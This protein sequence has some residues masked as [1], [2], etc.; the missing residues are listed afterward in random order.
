MSL[1]EEL[2]EPVEDYGLFVTKEE[3]DEFKDVSKQLVRGVG[4][5]IHRDL[6]IDFTVDGGTYT[7]NGK[8][9]TLNTNFPICEDESDLFACLH[10][11]LAHIVFKSDMRY[12]KKLF[13]EFPNVNRDVIA[14]ILNIIEDIRIEHAWGKL[15]PGHYKA[16]LSLRRNMQGDDVADNPLWVLLQIRAGNK[17]IDN[18]VE[19]KLLPFVKS[20][21]SKLGDVRNS[22]CMASVIVTKEIIELITDYYGDST[23]CCTKCGKD[24][25]QK[26][27]DLTKTHY[28]A[29]VCTDCA[30]DGGCGGEGGKVEPS[31]D[32][33][34]SSGGESSNDG[35]GTDQEKE[36]TPKDLENMNDELEKAID[37]LKDK[38]WTLGCNNDEKTRSSE[39]TLAGCSLPFGRSRAGGTDKQ[40]HDNTKPLTRKYLTEEM[41][42]SQRRNRNLMQKAI[43]HI[44]SLMSQQKNL[45]HKLKEN[46]KDFGGESQ[47]EID[48]YSWHKSWEP[49]KPRLAWLGK[50]RALTGEQSY[51]RKKKLH[52]SGY[53]I[54]M[55]KAVTYIASGMKAS[56]RNIFLRKSNSGKSLSICFVVDMSSSMYGEDSRIVKE[57]ML[58]TEEA[59]QSINAI[60]TDYIVFES[61]NRARI[62]DKKLLATVDAQGGTY[63]TPAIVHGANVLNHCHYGDE[64]VLLLLSDGGHED[65]ERALDYCTERN[66]TPFVICVSA[67]EKDWLTS[68]YGE[69]Y[70]KNCITIDNYEEAVD[71]I[72]D[73]VL[74]KIKE[75]LQ[76]K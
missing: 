50:V 54:K 28:G 61:N 53:R 44:G 21:K 41:R 45:K 33:G 10:H 60:T 49:S 18:L 73:W 22:S 64:K 11:E 48:Q 36:F 57:L 23:P 20:V 72:M 66:I 35:G 12:C 7:V 51:A 1:E 67:M 46:L 15:Y 2:D 26:E 24:M 68:L 42:L 16:F 31:N 75:L 9:I 47:R 71:E 69:K 58:T 3:L 29:G 34:E 43:K 76:K 4:K 63:C 39:Q 38:G 70:V 19:P 59:V 65:V 32:G 14:Q 17:E 56:N 40:I 74:G 55:N 13:K 25:E 52:S 30:E 27:N 62:T 6:S 5:A 37:D 8:D